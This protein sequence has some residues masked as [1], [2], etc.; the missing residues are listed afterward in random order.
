MA[1][2]KN[3]V[4]IGSGN[5]AT[6]LALT[7]TAKKC[8]IT[9]IYS[10]TKKNAAA[11]AK[12]ISAKTSFSNKIKDIDTTA[13][14]YIIAVADDAIIKITRKLKLKNK[15]VVHTSGSNEMTILKTVSKNYGVIYPLQTFSLNKHIDFKMVPVFIEANSKSNS[16]LLKQFASLFS[17]NVSKL[18]S[19]ERMQLHI[20][21]VVACN[22][23]NHLF[24][25]A[26]QILSKNKLN[27]KLLKPLIE[28]TVAKALSQSPITAQTGPAVRNDFKTVSAHIKTLSKN[29]KLKKIYQLISKSIIDT[30]R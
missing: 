7:L 23:T 3:I 11:L 5:V 1:A 26:E 14:L 13:D 10:R 27:F 28:E 29:K 8:T 22:F 21:A 4:I 17:D 25:L 2:I 9:Q 24:V 30:H 18:S 20:A 6:H 15:L 12:K 16:V 19:N